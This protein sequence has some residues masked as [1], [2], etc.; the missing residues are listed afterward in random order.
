MQ[1]AP[2]VYLN[3]KSMQNNGL[4]GYSYGFRAIVLHTFGV[5]VGLRV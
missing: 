2:K 5:K 3:P 4:D 1:E